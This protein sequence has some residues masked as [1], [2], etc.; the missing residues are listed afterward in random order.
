VQSIVT[1]K[2]ERIHHDS[3]NQHFRGGREEAR[4]GTRREVRELAGLAEERLQI[5]SQ[6]DPLDRVRS[7]VEREMAEVE[8]A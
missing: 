7:S 5:E 4:G 3:G 2:L 8:A 6:A 1:F